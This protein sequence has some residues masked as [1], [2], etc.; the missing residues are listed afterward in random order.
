MPGTRT[1]NKQLPRIENFSLYDQRYVRSA[2]F[3]K[4]ME[5]FLEAAPQF[6]LQ[7]RS[8]TILIWAPGSTAKARDSTSFQYFFG[9]CWHRRIGEPSPPGGNNGHRWEARLF[10]FTKEKIGL[11]QNG[12]AFYPRSVLPPRA[13]DSPT[14]S[15]KIWFLRNFNSNWQC[16]PLVHQHHGQLGQTCMPVFKMI[17]KFG[18]IYLKTWIGGTSYGIPLTFYVRQFI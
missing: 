10:G 12:L 7:V 11:G 13:D 1:H 4:T 9:V 6:V 17:F 15:W 14:F 5:G 2:F 18:C 3:F 16:Y 8:N